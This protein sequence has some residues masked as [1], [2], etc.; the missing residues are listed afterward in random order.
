MT[1][2]IKLVNY[3]AGQGGKAYV[4]SSRDTQAFACHVAHV[5]HT[6]RPDIKQA[7]VERTMHSDERHIRRV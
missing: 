2:A 3:V 7:P 5:T 4:Y 1:T 6:H